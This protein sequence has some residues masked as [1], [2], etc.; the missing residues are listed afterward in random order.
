M[1]HWTFWLIA[2]HLLSAPL[3]APVIKV[4]S[5]GKK[6]AMLAWKDVPQEK[7]RGFIVNYTLYY[8]TVNRSDMQGESLTEIISGPEHVQTPLSKGT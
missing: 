5:L 2:P 3:E 4:V 1:F 6:D 8:F 7:Q